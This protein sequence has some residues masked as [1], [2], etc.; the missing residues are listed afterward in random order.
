MPI[1]SVAFSTWKMGC[2]C[3]APVYETLPTVDAL[4]ANRPKPDGDEFIQMAVIPAPGMLSNEVGVFDMNPSEEITSTD[5]QPPMPDKKFNPWGTGYYLYQ[6]K[7]K[8]H[9]D[10]NLKPPWI[11]NISSATTWKK[12]HETG[13]SGSHDPHHARSYHLEHATQQIT[14]VNNPDGL[15]WYDENHITPAA[16]KVVIDKTYDEHEVSAAD[17]ITFQLS[18]DYKVGLDAEQPGVYALTLHSRVLGVMYEPSPT[19]C[20]GPMAGG[21]MMF[22]AY[23]K[24]AKAASAVYINASLPPH[25][26]T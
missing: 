13:L 17:G 3:S 23:Q 7:S 8:L 6:N 20:L 24:Y 19:G 12:G 22:A 16:W 25:E 15:A 21:P 5:D 1:F 26:Q 10:P 4:F 18:N 14:V 9:D 2:C 11:Y